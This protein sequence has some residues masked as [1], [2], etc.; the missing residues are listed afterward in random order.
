[1]ARLMKAGSSRGQL[2]ILDSVNKPPSKT[3][4]IPARELVQVMAKVNCELIQN[5][6]LT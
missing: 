3:L 1:M 6:C 5:L 4:I 2:D